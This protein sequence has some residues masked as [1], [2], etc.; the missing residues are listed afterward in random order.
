MFQHQKD[1]N[2]FSFIERK[3]HLS[4]KH[5]DDINSHDKYFGGLIKKLYE[6]Y[7]TTENK[8]VIVQSYLEIQHYYDEIDSFEV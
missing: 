7:N 3:D 5:Q 8:E 4:Q 2:L 1:K 6:K